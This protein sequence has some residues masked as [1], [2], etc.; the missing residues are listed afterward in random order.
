MTAAYEVVCGSDDRDAWLEQRKLGLGSSDAPSILGVSPFRS[1]LSVYTDKLGLTVDEEETEAQKWGKILEPHI[2]D[3]FGKETGR[4]VWP[5]GQL[6]RSTALPWQMATLDG[7]QRNEKHGADVGLVEAK[8]T[9]WRVGDWAEGVP[10]HVFTQVQHQLAVTGRTW[11]SVVV[12]LNG[13][14]LLWADVERDNAFIADVLIPAE[15][16]FWQRVQD[17]EPVDPDGSASARE[18]LR[19]LYPNAVPGKFVD[20][21]GDLM[22]VD[23]LLWELKA[24]RKEAEQRIEKAEQ[25]IKAAIGDAD[26]GLFS[27]GISYTFRLQKRK[28]FTVEPTEFRVLRRSAASGR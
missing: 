23:K 12:L 5:A 11:G 14:K 19:A 20:L 24:E 6:L 15:A 3:E 16:D 7:E 21:P 25:Q 28:G 18:A 13:C 4:A 27:N 17:R 9:G 8:A 10:M 26:A 22:E 2:L 1:A